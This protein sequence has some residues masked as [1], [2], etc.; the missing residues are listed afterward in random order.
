MNITNRFTKEMVSLAKSYCDNPVEAA[1]AFQ[2]GSFAED[3]MISLHR[4]RIFL[5]ETN[6]MIIDRLEVVPPVLEI[7]GLGAADISGYL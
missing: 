6:E 7:V 2:A 1:A 5:G 3:A 4:L